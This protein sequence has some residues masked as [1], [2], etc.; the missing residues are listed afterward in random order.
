MSACGPFRGLLSAHL[1]G[2]LD[3]RDQA[4]LEAHLAGCPACRKDLEDLRRTV[5]GIRA[6]EPV[7]P[8]PWLA[9]RILE[10]V[11]HQPAPRRGRILALARRPSLQAAGVL[12]ICTAGYLALRVSG[13]FAGSGPLPARRSAPLEPSPSAQP[14][15]QAPTPS[16]GA[17]AADRAPSLPAPSAKPRQPGPPGF[18]PPPPAAPP[19]PPAPPSAPGASGSAAPETEPRARELQERFAAQDLAASGAS[20]RAAKA[21]AAPGRAPAPEAARK[22]A[23]AARALVFR[24]R[25]R[26]PAGIQARVVAACRE[27]GATFPA[28]PRPETGVLAARVPARNLPALLDRLEE[29]GVLEGARPDPSAAPEGDLEVLIF[30]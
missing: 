23:P 14:P 9:E 17:K 24:L 8:P 25:P 29:M 19:P 22:A 13:T 1:D 5:E 18:A 2:A 12:L 16:P 10:R 15:A 11:R 20:A 26:D 27:A 3:P 6:L 30:W 4:R 21:Q 28:A 7:E